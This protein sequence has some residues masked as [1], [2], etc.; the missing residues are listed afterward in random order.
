MF[1]TLSFMLKTKPHSPPNIFL[2]K[3]LTIKHKY[4]TNHATNKFVYYTKHKLKTKICIS[5]RGP[6]K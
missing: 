5:V 2:N 1:Q 6:T 4:S 3:F